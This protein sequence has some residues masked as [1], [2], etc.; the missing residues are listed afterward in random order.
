[1]RGLALAAVL[2]SPFA[3]AA[4]G[5]DGAAQ[6]ERPRAAAVA[7]PVTPAALRARYGGLARLTADVVQVK[8]GKYWARPFESRVKLRYTP[9]RVEWETVAPVK[10]LA[11]IEGSALWLAGPDGKRRDLG[12]AAGDPRLAALLGFVR[13]L[14]AVDL[15]AIERD[16]VVA[17][18]PGT[19]QATPRP[20]ST[21]ALFRSVKLRFAEDLTI[22]TVEL[23]TAE[24]RTLLRFERVEQQRAP[25]ARGLG[26]DTQERAPAA[27]QPGP[28]A[29]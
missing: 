11:V 14:L 22:A 7:E 29:P 26:P 3:A 1:V 8:E 28:A 20:G 15:P 10:A 9:A 16:F 18:G 6:D 23:E 27:R 2:A 19:L 25:D 21:L 12:P 24:E 4:P 13:A 17:Y 5:G